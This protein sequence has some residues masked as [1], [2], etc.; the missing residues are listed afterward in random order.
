MCPFLAL[1]LGLFLIIALGVFLVLVLN[2]QSAA[3]VPSEQSSGPETQSIGRARLDPVW[4][5]LGGG[6]GLQVCEKWS[7]PGSG[8]GFCGSAAEHIC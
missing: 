2:S 7:T 1:V 4:V 3:A 8:V 6:G 5:F